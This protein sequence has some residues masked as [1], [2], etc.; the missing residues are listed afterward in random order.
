MPREGRDSEEL[1]GRR[2]AAARMEALDRRSEFRLYIHAT[3]E[4]R[5]RFRTKI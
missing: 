2:S 1:R 4:A 5:D 3:G